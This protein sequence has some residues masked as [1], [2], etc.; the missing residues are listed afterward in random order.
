MA[1]VRYLCKTCGGECVRNG[2]RGGLVQYRCT[3]CDNVYSM[4]AGE[5]RE[6][7][8]P[9]KKRIP[10]N[11]NRTGG[12]N[13]G[14]VGSFEAGTPAPKAAEAPKPYEPPKAAGLPNSDKAVRKWHIEAPLFPIS[15][16][17]IYAQ[18][19]DSVMEVRAYSGRTLVSGSGF[20]LGGGYAVTNAHVVVKGGTPARRLEVYI[21][22]KTCTAE[23]VALG[24]G[25]ADGDD[26]A[27]LRIK[28]VPA[29]VK[30]VKFADFSQV[31]NGQW[32]FV[33]GNS[34][35]GGTCI[36]AGIVSDRLRTVEGKPRLMTDCAINRGNSGGPVFN[37]LGEVVGAVVAVTTAAEGMNYAIPSDRVRAFAKRY[38]A[39]V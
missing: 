32:L 27:L 26:L 20:A 33:I 19:I 29:A 21:C 1:V 10:A 4:R 9:A 30:P 39:P 15:G 25:T 3:C 22:G 17:D 36:T 37:A 35:G 11:I 23:I 12:V 2:E 16:E 8:T 38:G 14:A 34:L 5:E 28:D 7:F 31:K 24:T 18:C 13:G 6:F